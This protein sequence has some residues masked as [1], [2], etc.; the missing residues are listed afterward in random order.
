MIHSAT[1][2]AMGCRI[3]AAIEKPMESS[4]AE[5]ARVPKWFEEWEQCLSRFRSDSELNAVNHSAGHPIHVSKSFLDVLHVAQQA[6]RE[7]ENLV[8]PAI[9]D[10][11]VAAGYDT[12]FDQMHDG[13]LGPMEQDYETVHSL[14]EIQ[15]DI[16]SKAIQL[17]RDFHLDFGGIAK[18]WAA[19]QTANRLKSL[20]TALVNAGG[21][22]S[23][24]G[25]M[26]NGNYWSVGVADPANPADNLVILKLGR[27]GV[28]TSG[29]DYRR[30]KKDGIW[31]HHIIDPRTGFPAVTD[32]L[33]AT[34]IAPDVMIAEMN[35]KMAVILGSD[36]ALDWLDANPSLAGILVLKSGRIV[37]SQQFY[38]YLWRSNDQSRQ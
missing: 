31:Q 35:A 13:T 10:Q 14:S 6:E 11:L 25:R 5:L 4:P 19:H 32:V 16:K 17:P 15:V 29:T 12:S 26:S 1:F 2:K 21:D 9:H 38:K 20:G 23:I 36:G 24:S 34:V 30:W 18:G 33:G 28:A 3:F 27:C 37:R 22:V 7:S 8:T